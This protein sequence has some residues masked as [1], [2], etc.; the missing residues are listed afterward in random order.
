MKNRQQNEKCYYCGSDK[1]LS[2]DHIPGR[3]FGV[4]GAE[5]GIIVLA[6]TGCNHGWHKDQEFVRLRITLHAGSSEGAQY[7]QH[8]ELSR[9]KPKP[10]KRP[11]IARYRREASKSFSVSGTEYLGLTDADHMKF[12]NVVKHWAAALHYWKTGAV[13]S[14][15]KEMKD[16]LAS[17]KLDP[18]KL[19]S[20]LT[21]QQTGT[22][23]AQDGEFARW[24]YVAGPKSDQSVVAFRLLKSDALWFFVR[25]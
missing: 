16:T 15:P 7:I 11:E 14:I 9:L 20:K 22:W 2:R 12:C 5:K 23:I 17:P 24:W 3:L 13:A 1:N 19:Q 10:G 25:F 18:V 4:T 8:R 6:C 21:G